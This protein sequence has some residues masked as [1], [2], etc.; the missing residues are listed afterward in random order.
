MPINLDAIGIESEPHES[1]WDSKDCLLYSLGVGAGAS[2]PTGFEL[3]FTTENTKEVAQKV[4]PTMCVV[5]GA[6]GKGGPLTH[7]GE[8]DYSK[9]VHG[10]QE[11]ILHKSLPTSATV[12]STSKIS[13]I[14]DKEKAALVILETTAVDSADGE[15]MFT[16]ISKLFFRGEGGWGGDRGPTERFEFP[17]READQ[18]ISYSTRPD[19]ALLYRL[20]G[21]RNPL[22]SDPS[23][24]AL[25]GFPKPILHG[26]C[27]YGFTGRALL[28]AVCG[29]E[30]EKFHSMAG[31]FSSPVIPGEDLE[32]HI[33]IDGKQAKFRTL[34]SDRVV[35]DNGLLSTR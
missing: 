9:M 24:A 3:E 25:G 18:I 16:N 10:E 7:I 22:H 13:N 29:S 1:S 21:D 4:L 8:V 6:T 23:F 32:I 11:V 33:W 2:D 34:A 19:Q 27:T 5:L 26:L 20:N 31:R 15:P 30:P 14:F 35:L 28:H 12:L 17:D